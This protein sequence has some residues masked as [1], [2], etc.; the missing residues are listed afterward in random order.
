MYELSSKKYHG[1]G[2]YKRGAL[3]ASKYIAQQ[4]AEVGLE[5]MGQEG[6]Y[7]SFPMQANVIKK[8]GLWING[9]RLRNGIQFL[10]DCGNPTIKVIHTVPPGD[11]GVSIL[12]VFKTSKEKDLREVLEKSGEVLIVDTIQGG[13]VLG[14]RDVLM[15]AK[16]C[17]IK[18]II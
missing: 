18:T 16:R 9:T 7:Q 4:M 11:L 5:P 13:A 3:R 17:G 8:T 12:K 14:R 2:Y 15:Q 6:F 10:P 1:R